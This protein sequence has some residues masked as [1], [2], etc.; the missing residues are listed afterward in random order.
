MEDI[1]GLCNSLSLGKEE[2]HTLDLNDTVLAKGVADLQAGLVGK[3]LIKKHYNRKA[4]KEVVMRI[5]GIELEVAI[6]GIDANVI[7]FCFSNAVE[8]R[9][10]FELEPWNF[11]KA[12]LV[13]NASDDWDSL[14][15]DAFRFTK[16][17]VQIYNLPLYGMLEEVGTYIANLMGKCIKVDTGRNGKYCGKYMR[18]EYNLT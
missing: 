6:E 11:H 5:W 16:F 4:F 3:L 10:V 1:V 9:R 15:E 2:E 18:A 14:G 13:L 7:I 17:W 8:C 12:L